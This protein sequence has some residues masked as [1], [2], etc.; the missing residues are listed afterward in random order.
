MDPIILLKN[1]QKKYGRVT[2]LKDISLS[3]NQG[4]KVILTGPNG[5]GKTT[6]LKI[7]SVQISPSAGSLIIN[8][9][10]ALKNAIDVKRILSL[11]GHR[12]FLYDELTV[13]ENLRFYGGFY[14]VKEE[15]LSRVIEITNL[16]Q[17]LETR[18]G[19]LSYGYKKRV[20][21]AR[22]LL[23]KPKILTLDELFSGLDSDSSRRVLDSLKQFDGTI[24]LSTHTLEWA[25]EL[26]KREIFL[27]E[28][29]IE[30][31]G[32]I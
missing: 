19:Y 31:D 30:R 15:D 21:I 23:A 11:V 4:E 18:V 9:V 13:D 29:M 27:R 17:K 3:I 32:K 25:N 5:A 28:G 22:A 1:I 24:I 12:S 6:L 14:D 20:D 2:A 8:G 10:D 16:K 26:C 7:I